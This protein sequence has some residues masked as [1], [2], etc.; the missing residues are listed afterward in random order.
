MIQVHTPF[1]IFTG[2]DGKPL[3]NGKVY[4][5]QVG[6]D[7]VVPANQIP[8]FWDEALT[9]P[10]AQ[11]LVT[12][13]GYIVRF[14]TPARVYTAT[15]YSMSVRNASNILVYYLAQFGAV[16]YLPADD[17][18]GPGGA[19]VVGYQP[20]GFGSIISTVKS[21][22]DKT[23][24]T[25]NYESLQAAHDAC[26]AAGGG[27][28][29]VVG[30]VASGDTFNWDIN[31]VFIRG[32]HG[33]VSR[34]DFRTMTG[35]ATPD[36]DKFAFE[37]QNPAATRARKGM[38]NLTI[39][40]PLASVGVSCF[41]L[42]SSVTDAITNLSFEGVT[43]LDFESQL[44]F[45]SQC[46]NVNFYN[47][48]FRNT[49]G[50]AFRTTTVIKT[51][52]VPITNAGECWTFSQCQFANVNKVV[53]N[54]T[55]VA[56]GWQFNQCALVYFNVLFDLKQP[57]RISV[58]QGHTESNNYDNH[59]VIVKGNGCTTR[60]TDHEWWFAPFSGGVPQITKEPFF[61]DN[62]VIFG[63]IRIKDCDY[64]ATTGSTVRYWSDRTVNG[65][66]SVEGWYAQNSNLRMPF[67]MNPGI[68]LEAWRAS[69]V[70]FGT[71]FVAE[72]GDGSV[73]AVSAAQP[74]DDGTGNTN[75][76]VI[77]TSLAGQLMRRYRRYPVKSGQNIEASIFLKS[78]GFSTDAS[79]FGVYITI[80][81]GNN[82][83]I[84]G[85]NPFNS[86][87]DV[88]DYTKVDLNWF[89][90]A[91]VGAAYY[92]FRIFAGAANG[93]NPRGIYLAEMVINTY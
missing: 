2:L 8:V 63:G 86:V 26:V 22:L 90:L 25:S 9:I 77:A 60:F 81:D 78:T 14:G 44:F 69:S 58:N 73:V 67:G 40:G 36:I 31:K 72:A 37:W 17:I 71:G 47:C 18:T 66:V 23:F 53:E 41:P 76:T 70:N 64:H 55:G 13:A 10:A 50:A 27:I 59:W 87:G 88:A 20:P 82:V 32:Q 46:S 83:A 24:Y 35:P 92:E 93:N 56:G 52:A 75:V 21:Q 68:Q 48:F 91:P 85:G 54:N 79:G 28:L 30:N 84:G 34:L 89:P 19:G 11:P 38:A 16:D 1:D 39:I 33:G 57:C 5:G 42:F 49:D 6:T 80:F 61:C 74:F 62:D 7:P 45:G 3:S 12:N 43:I 4:I 29:V 65:P 15:D 51:P